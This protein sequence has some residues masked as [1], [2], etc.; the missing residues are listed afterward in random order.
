MPVIVPELIP[1]FGIL[2]A[3]IPVT[4][5]TVSQVA[6]S[7]AK[8]R[9]ESE[10]PAEVDKLVA[11]IALLQEEVEALSQQVKRLEAVQEFD[12]KLLGTREEKA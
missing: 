10:S 9:R 7:L 4:G 11:Q 6:K 12:R 8:T 5:F 3:M 2:L 1:I